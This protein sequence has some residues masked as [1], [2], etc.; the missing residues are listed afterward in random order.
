ML[1]F[2]FPPPHRLLQGA[3]ECQLEDPLVLEHSG[4]TER[5]HKGVLYGSA[6]RLLGPG[7]RL[8]PEWAVDKGIGAKYLSVIGAST[9]SAKDKR[10]TNGCQ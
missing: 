3:V 7:S 2:P 10:E 1:A 4:G 6:Q 5:R 8:R 9:C